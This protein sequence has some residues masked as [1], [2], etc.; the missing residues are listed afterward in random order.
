M[1]AWR[2]FFSREQGLPVGR[3]EREHLAGPGRDDRQSNDVL[4]PDHCRVA[5]VKPY[6]AGHP[7]V[8]CAPAHRTQQCRLLQMEKRSCTYNTS[9]V[10]SFQFEAIVSEHCRRIR[11]SPFAFACVGAY[12]TLGKG[13]YHSISISF[14]YS[15]P[16]RWIARSR[17]V[18]T[19]GSCS[20]RSSTFLNRVHD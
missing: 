19:S 10:P 1:A 17:V 13:T 16:P 8:T 11:I 2:V 12:W 4:S 7:S 20:I 3:P 9:R 5:S 15:Y 6:A 18:V 14:L